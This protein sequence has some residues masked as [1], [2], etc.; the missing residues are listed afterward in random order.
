MSRGEQT[1]LL[2]EP[3]TVARRALR[4]VREA[5]LLDQA[6]L[7]A[8]QLAVQAL[9]PAARGIENWHGIVGCWRRT[10]EQHTRCPCPRLTDKEG[11]ALRNVAKRCKSPD[12]TM[13]VIQ[14]F[15]SWRRSTEWSQATDPTT[16]GLQRHC[17]RVQEYLAQKNMERA[18][19]AQV[20]AQL[21]PA[22]RDQVKVEQVHELI[23]SLSG[24]GDYAARVQ[25]E[26]D[27]QRERLADSCLE[28]A[29]R[30]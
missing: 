7:D 24:R 14:A 11:I 12:L 27:E 19:Q 1:S 15:W 26:R 6:E 25:R 3:K 9:E 16:F 29:E 18:R 8:L 28:L 30:L 17:A 20:E 23:R 21:E 22:V 13:A 2:G 4:R 5:G 10:Y